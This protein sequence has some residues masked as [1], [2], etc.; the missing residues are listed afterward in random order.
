[1]KNAGAYARKFNGLLRRIKTKHGVEPPEPAEPICQ[2]VIA[3]LEWNASRGAAAAAYRRVM[4]KMV[5]VNDLR[6]SHP[7]E[8]E[9]M[10]GSRFPL[11]EQ[12]VARLHEALNEIF[13]REQ[14]ASLDALAGRSKKDVRAYLDSLPGMPPYVAAQVTLFCFGGHAVP[15]DDQLADLLRQEEVVDP[16]ADLQEIESFLTHRIK[17]DKAIDAHAALMAWV[18]AGSR[19]VSTAKS[20]QAKATNSSKKKGKPKKKTTKTRR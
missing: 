13:Q 10:V 19:R 6:V 5:D 14:A 20:I 8:V 4:S 16:Q 9:V 15:I 3:F 11:V 18:D 17:A 12:R 7:H 1:M 2:L